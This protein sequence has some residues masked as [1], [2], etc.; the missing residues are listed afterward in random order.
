[1]TRIAKI[2]G[3]PLIY[4]LLGGCASLLP[5]IEQTTESPWNNYEAAR[6]AFD[7]IQPGS[8]RTEELKTMGFDPFRY[9]NIKLLNYL[10]VMRYFLPN[11]SVR[12]TDLPPDVQD[13][14]QV[15]TKCHGYEVSSGNVYRERQGNAF[16]DVFNFRR[17]TKTSGWQFQGLIIL[18]DG[19]VAYK[20][21]SGRPNIREFEDKKN[22]LGPIQDI[23]IP[24]QLPITY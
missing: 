19:Q 23:T 21:E 7:Q 18:N 6:Q 14:L 24:S 8:T 12:L 20:L 1:M 2:T 22:P 13:C 17:K 15:K 16:L 10:E 3:I 5:S 11:E 4:L 9:P